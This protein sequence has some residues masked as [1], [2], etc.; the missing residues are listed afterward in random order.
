[1]GEVEIMEFSELSDVRFP[2]MRSNVISAIYALANR[3]HQHRVWIERTYPREGYYDDFTLNLNVLYDDTLVL[4]D[5]AATLGTVLRS[6]DE[7]VAMGTLAA[8]IDNLLRQEGDGKADADYM[9]S[10]LWDAVVR[11]A[12]AAYE[13]MSVVPR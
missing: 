12:L 2:D 5:P 8:A 3:E 9:A 11:S 4:D 10:P 1:M 13:I 6:Q 7:V